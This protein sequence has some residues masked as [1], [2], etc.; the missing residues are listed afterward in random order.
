MIPESEDASRQ[1]NMQLTV[2][3]TLT[4]S[5]YARITI[6]KSKFR[7]YQKALEKHHMSSS[8]KQNRVE[9]GSFAQKL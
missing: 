8:S 7:V 4:I 3:T 5:R 9:A 2:E 6:M 1:Q